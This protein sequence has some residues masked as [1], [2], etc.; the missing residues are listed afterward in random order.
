MGHRTIKRVPLD[1]DHP[2]NEVWPGYL[3]PSLP[4][5]TTCGGDGYGVEARAVARTFYPHMIDGP[6]ADALAWHDKIG[7]AE[8]DHLVEQGRLRVWRD[9]K[10]RSEPRTAAEVNAEQGPGRGLDGHDGINR[11]IL[12]KFRCERLG[13]VT[14][15]GTCDGHGTVAT[16]TER[17][18]NEEW[19][20]TEPPVGVGWQLWETVSEGSPVSPVFVTAEY[21]ADWCADNAT[22]F[23]D[24]TA[25][26]DQWLRMFENDT[27]DVDTLLVLERRAPS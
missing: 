13:I 24:L 12:T 10:W 6:N 26:R 23:A 22:T 5:C 27:T 9:G 25:T 11:W 16:D 2:L 14:A 17:E 8:V 1:F 15:C 7:Q 4:T 20:G 18:A 21:L 3:S 19:E